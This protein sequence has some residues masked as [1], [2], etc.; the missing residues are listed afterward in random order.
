MQS[1]EGT[2]APIALADC[3]SAAGVVTTLTCGAV[4]SISGNGT[5]GPIGAATTGGATT[6][7]A[8]CGGVTGRTG[9]AGRLLATGAGS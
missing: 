6:A 2:I 9:V 7:A 3:G 8:R 5:R 1:G 4:L